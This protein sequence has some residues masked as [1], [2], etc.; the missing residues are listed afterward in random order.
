M[1]REDEAK[2]MRSQELMPGGG[3]NQRR[4]RA[5]G[6]LGWEEVAGRVAWGRRDVQTKPLGALISAAV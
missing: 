1:E 2:R 5:G 6:R 3:A 4:K